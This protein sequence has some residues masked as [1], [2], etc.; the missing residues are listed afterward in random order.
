MRG[1]IRG[2]KFKIDRKKN[3]DRLF[4]PGKLGMSAD[5]FP[6]ETRLL[7]LNFWAAAAV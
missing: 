6:W 7:L 4:C 3:E 1:R 5:I 2:S